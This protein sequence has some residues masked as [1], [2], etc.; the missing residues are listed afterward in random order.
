MWSCEIMWQI[1]N[2]SLLPQSLWPPNL[3]GWWLTMTWHDT[4]NACFCEV[5]WQIKITETLIAQCLWSPNLPGW[6]YTAMNSH[7]VILSFS[8]VVFVMSRDKLIHLICI[9]KRPISTKLGKVVAYHTRLQSLKSRDI[10]L[11]TIKIAKTISPLSQ[12]LW[13]LNLAGCW[14]QGGSL[15]RKRLDRLLV[16]IDCKNQVHMV[17]CKTSS[18]N[19][20]KVTSKGMFHQKN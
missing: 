1:K 7:S 20:A 12:D 13:S 17:I 8:H 14:H 11:V 19:L 4:L 6:W 16:S 3:S 9:C 18:W 5:I 2:I 10:M 15:E